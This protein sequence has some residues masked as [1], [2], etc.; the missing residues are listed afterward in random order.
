ME[1]GE[2]DADRR[3]AVAERIERGFQRRGDAERRLVADE[4]MLLVRIFG[5]PVPERAR[6]A[7]R[8]AA[9][10]ERR[11]GESAHEERDIHR[12]RAGDDLVRHVLA[13]AGAD[14]PIARIG[15]A[16]IAPVRTERHLLP[17]LQV[18][19]DLLG[20]ALLV[21]LPVGEHLRRTRNP[22]VR[23]ELPRAARILARDD[24]SAAKRL[25]RPRTQVPEIPDRRGNDMK[26]A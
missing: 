2:F 9:E 1:L 16:R 7:R 24:R 11:R 3:L 21:A 18:R 17:R 15:N 13:R 8:E 20:D 12:A 6:S 14:Q 23:Q 5:E 22:E 26:H 10:R 25:K 19:D 4:R